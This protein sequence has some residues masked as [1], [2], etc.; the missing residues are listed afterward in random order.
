MAGATHGA[1]RKPAV[2]SMS[3]QDERAPLPPSAVL[4]GATSV[5]ATCYSQHTTR[6]PPSHNETCTQRTRARVR[7][8][9]CPATPTTK[10]GWRA[11]HA[12]MR[13]RTSQHKNAPLCTSITEATHGAAHGKLLKRVLRSQPTTQGTR[14]SAQCPSRANAA[15]Q[16]LTQTTKLAPR[17][18]DQHMCIGA[19]KRLGG[20][21]QLGGV[22]RQQHVPRPVPC[23]C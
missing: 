13:A 8:T 19:A 14:D 12:S 11:R 2:T 15:T 21:T 22:G 18:S 5:S 9:G 7:S 1:P 23:R 4:R 16:P 17:G 6:P 10:H 3:R 20:R